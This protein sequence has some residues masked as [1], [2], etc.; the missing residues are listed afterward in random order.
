VEAEQKMKERPGPIVLVVDDN[1]HVSSHI[2]A[3]LELLDCEAIPIASPQEC[4]DM[5]KRLQSSNK[6]DAVI[7]SGVEA[8]RKGGYLISQIKTLDKKI[9]TLAIVRDKGDR[10]MLLSAGADAVAI[11]PVIGQT[12]AFKAL[13][14]ISD[15]EL[16]I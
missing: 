3:I 15:D 7:L 9:K 12:I 14:L 13:K 16:Y 2:S 10:H 8:I 11:K 5:L 6:I 4:V 1:V